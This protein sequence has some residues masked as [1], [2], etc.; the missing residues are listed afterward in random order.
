MGGRSGLGMGL[1]TDSRSSGSLSK[2]WRIKE[3]VESEVWAASEEW[4][5][6]LVEHWEA[7]LSVDV[8]R[9]TS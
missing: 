2:S 6:G 3:W 4:W 5:L 7:L 1:D 8:H 9:T